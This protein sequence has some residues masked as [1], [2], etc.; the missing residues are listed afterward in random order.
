[1]AVLRSECHPP[2]RLKAGI[3]PRDQPLQAGAEP[4][5]GFLGGSLVILEELLQEKGT[6]QTSGMGF[7]I[8]QVRRY[9][10]TEFLPCTGMR[11]EVMV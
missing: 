3:Q 6:S 4:S 8:I 5:C 2:S 9:P 7:A 10:R 1:M 11:D